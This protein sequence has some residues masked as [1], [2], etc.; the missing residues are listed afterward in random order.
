MKNKELRRSCHW[1]FS[2]F[3]FQFSI[4]IFPGAASSGPRS[5]QACVKKLSAGGFFISVSALRLLIPH[6]LGAIVLSE[7]PHVKGGGRA[8]VSAIRPILGRMWHH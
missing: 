2:I 4:L 5:A 7:Q 6:R 3:N 8:C 1:I